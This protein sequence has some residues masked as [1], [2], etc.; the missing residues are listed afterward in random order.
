MKLTVQQ[1]HNL[2]RQRNER[3]NA[4][5]EEKERRATAVLEK[6]AALHRA[7]KAS[8]APSV[9][10]AEFHELIKVCPRCEEFLRT[11]SGFREACRIML[12]RLEHLRPL[13]EWKPQGKSARAIFRSLANHLLAKYP[14]PQFLW[15]AFFDQNAEFLVPL[16]DHIAKGGS[17]YKFMS[18]TLRLPLTRRACHE[19]LRTPSELS[20]LEGIRFAQVRSLGGTHTLAR[21]VYSWRLGREMWSV[22]DEVFW[23]TVI[24]WLV[25]QSML[26][27]TQ[28]PSILDYLHY[29][30]AQDANFSMKGR[31]ALAVLREKDAWHAELAALKLPLHRGAV[32]YKPSGIQGAEFELGEEGRNR[33]VWRIFEFLTAKD[34]HAEGKRMGHC[35][36]SYAYRIERGEVSIWAM[37]KEDGTGNWA[38]LTLEVNNTTKTVVQARGRFNRAPTGK[39]REILYRWTGNAGLS[40]GSFL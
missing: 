9:I 19:F 40:V 7:M 35:V 25:A 22:T 4:R 13:S 30:R 37:T 15:Q 39:E 27:T 16:A 29:R 20:V 33:E 8:K 31:T 28:V 26:D 36:F 1:R 12:R 3:R 5:K 10:D 2:I 6:E 11:Y 21:A 24:Q 17:L 14:T 23:N 32:V 34:L 38:Q 18:E